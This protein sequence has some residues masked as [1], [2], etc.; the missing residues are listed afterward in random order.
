MTQDTGHRRQ[1][2]GHRIQDTGHRIQETG[3]RIQGIGKANNGW[4]KKISS[5]SYAN[6]VVVGRPEL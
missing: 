6:L 5:P 1:D 4:Q 3:H 2:T